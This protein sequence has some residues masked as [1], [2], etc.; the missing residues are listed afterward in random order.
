[1]PPV[2]EST[3]DAPAQ[4]VVVPVMLM[5]GNAFTVIKTVVL[6]TQPLASVALT[7]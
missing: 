2:A 7:V 1:M 5:F 3:V 6:P 4:M